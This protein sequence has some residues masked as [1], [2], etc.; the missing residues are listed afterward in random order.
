MENI[1]DLEL[2]IIRFDGNGEE[3]YADLIVGA[4]RKQIP[5]TLSYVAPVGDNIGVSWVC[6]VCGAK[7]ISTEDVFCYKCGQKLRWL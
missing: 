5:M 2:A 4:L 7:K 1:T 6:P 3:P